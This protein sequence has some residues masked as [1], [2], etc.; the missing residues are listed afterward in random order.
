VKAF[1]KYV[2]A[3]VLASGIVV[4]M[5]SVGGLVWIFRRCYPHTWVRTWTWLRL[6]APVGCCWPGARRWWSYE[7]SITFISP[8]VLRTKRSCTVEGGMGRRERLPHI[9]TGESACPT[10]VSLQFVGRRP[11]RDKA[12]ALALQRLAA[13]DPNGAE[14]V[15]GTLGG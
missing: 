9:W 5:V 3:V 8:G 7:S 14:F 11:I 15:P 2:S 12:E 10:F 6:S 4:I 13:L 1:W